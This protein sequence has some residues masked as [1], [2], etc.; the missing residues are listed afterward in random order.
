MKF[1][2]QNW[3]GLTVFVLGAATVLAAIFLLDTCADAGKFV[4]TANG[5]QMHMACTWTER[6]VIGLGGLI[7]VVGL[8][9]TFW[10]EA[11]RA[12]SLSTVASGALMLSIPLWLIPTCK[13]AMMVCNQSLKPGVLVLSGLIMVAGVAG[14]IKLARTESSQTHRMA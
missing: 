5:Q 7:A 13:S 10:K 3:R 12:L 11:A 4:Q 6:A 14:S 1:L 9:M 8:I 2:E